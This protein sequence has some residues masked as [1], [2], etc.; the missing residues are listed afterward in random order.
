MLLGIIRRQQQANQLYHLGNLLCLEINREI[1]MSFR[2]TFT[3]KN[4]YFFY[5]IGG[6]SEKP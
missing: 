2:R 5:K 1:N 6:A 4:C 3:A